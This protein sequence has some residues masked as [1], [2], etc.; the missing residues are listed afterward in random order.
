MADVAYMYIKDLKANKVFKGWT[1]ENK[2][3]H[4]SYGSESVKEMSRV[5]SIQHSITV[6]SHAQTGATTGA[7]R[8][9]PFVVTIDMDRILPELYR[10]QSLGAKL[11]VRV[12]FWSMGRP[13]VAS[14]KTDPKPHNGFTVHLD[15]ARVVGMSLHK[16]MALSGGMPDLVDI[17]FTY[18]KI[19]W[20]DHDDKIEAYYDWGEGG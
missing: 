13:D 1:G 12:H 16:P 9:T 10:S 11:E 14:G 5:Q 20:K 2:K 15:D 6:D 8:H 4:S 19:T 3:V 7:A 17:S 18:R